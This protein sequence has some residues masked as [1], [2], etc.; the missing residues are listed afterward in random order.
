MDICEGIVYSCV[1]QRHFC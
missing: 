1:N